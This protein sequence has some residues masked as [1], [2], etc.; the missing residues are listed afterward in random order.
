MA[1]SFRFIVAS[2]LCACM[3]IVVLQFYEEGPVPYMH[4]SFFWCTVQVSLFLPF[5]PFICLLVQDI[6]WC[7]SC[8]D[9]NMNSKLA[10]GTLKSCVLGSQTRLHNMAKGDVRWIQDDSS[11]SD[12]KVIQ[13]PQCWQS[14]IR[15]RWKY[16]FD[17]LKKWKILNLNFYHL[18]PS[19]MAYWLP[20]S[21]FLLPPTCHLL[22]PIFHLPPT[23]S[24]LLPPAYR[25]R[26][27]ATWG[28]SWLH[29]Q[30]S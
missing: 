21:S 6:A 10:V 15:V 13:P 14:R 2:S 11:N 5:C 22:L 19:T 3:T 29:K 12:S 1:I 18:A 9:R 26:V 30:G 7:I 8:F 4:H 24:Y 16:L 25:Q 23:T 27:K 20:T 17:D 28:W